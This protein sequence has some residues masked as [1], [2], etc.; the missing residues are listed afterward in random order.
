MKRLKTVL[1][2]N[3][4]VWSC[5]SQLSLL[6]LRRTASQKTESQIEGKYLSCVLYDGNL[7]SFYE[8]DIFTQLN[9]NRFLRKKT[10]EDGRSHHIRINTNS[11]NPF[12]I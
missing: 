5:I 6:R 1:S 11:Q 2:I 7:R 9:L 10:V 12:N 4:Q 3:D 8:A